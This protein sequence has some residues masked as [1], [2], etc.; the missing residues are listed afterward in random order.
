MQKRQECQSII[1][2]SILHHLQQRIKSGG[3]ST[4]VGAVLSALRN[5]LE[6]SFLYTVLNTSEFPQELLGT[7]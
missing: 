1:Q 3:V 6:Y 7:N 5:F 4:S 2:P